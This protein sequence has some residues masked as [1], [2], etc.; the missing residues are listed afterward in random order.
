MKR[1]TRFDIRHAGRPIMFLLGGLAAINVVFFLF[2]VQPLVREYRGLDDIHSPVF[3]E[4]SRYEDIVERH[5]RFL[6]AVRKAESDLDTIRD[7]IL[8]TREKRLVEVQGELAKLCADF[9]ISLDS[10]GFGNELLLSEELDRFAMEVPLEGNYTNLRKFLQA[11]ENSDKFI[12]VERIA[13]RKGKQGGVLLSLNISL[14]TYFT[15]PE[16]LIE[17]KRADERRGRRRRS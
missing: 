2:W 1:W 14:A 7:E 8:S 15:A 10:V 4:L 17:Q 5:E 9:G 6:E 3:K 12:L 11:V 16:N 13:L